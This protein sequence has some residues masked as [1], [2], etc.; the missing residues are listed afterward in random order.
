MEQ[1]GHLD[2]SEL[3]WLEEQ[4][5]RVQGKASMVAFHHPPCTTGRYLDT[6][7]DLF[8]LIARYNV[9]RHPGRAHS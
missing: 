4:L 2:P 9:S 8:Q 6:D 5:K 1:Y 7:G 3:A